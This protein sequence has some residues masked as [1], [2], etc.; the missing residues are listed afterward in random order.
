MP[1][2]SPREP[3]ASG[4]AAHITSVTR[5]RAISSSRT[6]IR[7]GSSQLVTQ[8]VY[9]HTSHTMARSNAVWSAPVIVGSFSRWCDS[10]VSAN[11]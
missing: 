5:S 3:N 1:M 10:W 9:A 11:T 2:M 7:C 8:A 6:G 4:I